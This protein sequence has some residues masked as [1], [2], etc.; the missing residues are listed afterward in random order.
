MW[1]ISESLGI[2]RGATP[3]ASGRYYDS[4]LSTGYTT[5]AIS[6]NTL[7]AIPFLVPKTQTYTVISLEVTTLAAAKSIRMGIYTDTNGAPDA[8]VLDAGTVSVATTGSKTISISQSLSAGWY[9]L[10]VVSDGTPT[11]RA[12]SQTAIGMLGFTSG[13][14][15]TIHVGFSV[16]FT[17]AALPNPF[18]GGGAL[19]TGTAP[20]LMLGV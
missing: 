1:K 4:R 5:L 10:V 16:A 18:T 12:T 14:D 3:H 20:R 8:L 17:Y 19:M 11:V 2:M 15:T 7:Y 13:T 6:A 9:W